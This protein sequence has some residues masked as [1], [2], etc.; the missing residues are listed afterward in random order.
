MLAIRLIVYAAVS[1]Q[2][3]DVGSQPNAPAADGL[4]KGAVQGPGPS[5]LASGFV[6]AYLLVAICSTI[7]WTAVLA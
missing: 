2:A 6:V 7:R 4:L 5:R 1:K 3:S